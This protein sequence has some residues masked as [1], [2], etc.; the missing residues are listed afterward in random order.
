MSECFPRSMLAAVMWISFVTAS[1]AGDPK[2][3]L[4]VK[5][6][7]VAANPGDGSADAPAAAPQVPML[8]DGYAVRPAWN[9]AGVDYAVGYASG[10]T[11]KDPSTISM[12]GVSVDTVN[13]VIN[14]N[15]SNVTLN[16]YDFSLAGGWGVT[17]NSGSNITIE[18]SKFVVGSNVKMPIYVTSG[19]SNVT[20]QYNVID[21]GGTTQQMLVGADGAGT[22]TIQHNL[23]QN[24]WGQNIVISSD[25]GGENWIVRYNVIQNAGLGFNQGAHGDWIQTYN[26]PGM[27]TNSFD[28]SFNTFVQNIP[29]AQGRTQGISAFSSNS[30]PD[31]GGVLNEAF[32]NNTFIANNGAYVNYG[33]IIDTARLIEAVTIRNNYFD[34]TNIGSANGGGGNWELIARSNGPY[35]GT[36]NQSNNINMV[37]GTLFGQRGTSIRGVV[38]SPSSG[39]VGAGGTIVL[40][41][42]FSAAVTV[43]SGVPTL[44]LNDGGVATYT[45]GSGTASLSFSHKVAPGQNTPSL[46]ATVVNLNRATV[47]NSWGRIVDLSLDGIPQAGPQ[48]TSSSAPH[49]Q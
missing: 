7:R 9:V 30:G 10:T 48:V 8:L 47:K 6:S 46:A 23:I 49:L 39:P 12:A 31:S 1:F 34:R 2:A 15:G 43:A 36:V 26:L 20:I 22:T 28:V 4:G 35:K 37:T 16:G 41:L 33:I 27:N 18:N 38:A 44:T 17:V 24:A 40:T 45:S 42:D 3:H 13:H 29:I 19:A 14:V 25:V 21:G 11:L 32:T 5:A